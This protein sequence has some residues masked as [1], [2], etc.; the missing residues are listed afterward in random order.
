MVRRTRWCDDPLTKGAYINYRPGQITRFGGLM[1]VEEEGGEVR[2]SGFGP[3]QFAGEWLS[4][5]WPG[6]MNGAVQ[7]GR[8][9]AEAVLAPAPAEAILT[10]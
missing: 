4:D 1:T 6:Y 9:A 7:T 3:V 8:L 2:A 10:R 5:A